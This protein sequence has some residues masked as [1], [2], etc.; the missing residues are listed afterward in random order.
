MNLPKPPQ[1]PFSR[2][3]RYQFP[4]QVKGIRPPKRATTP[5]HCS[6]L[7]GSGPWSRA[8]E[9]AVRPSYFQRPKPRPESQ[10]SIDA[11]QAAKLRLRAA[12]I[13]AAI[14]PRQ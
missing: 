10:A 13:R 12:T 4:S 9:V 7:P 6:P 11:R 3:W 14:F 2:Q 8:T 1:A 5:N